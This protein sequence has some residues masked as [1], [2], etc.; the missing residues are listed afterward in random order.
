MRHRGELPPA[1]ALKER[2]FLQ[3]NMFMPPIIFRS[4]FSLFFSTGFRP[5]LDYIS[6]SAVTVTPRSLRLYMP[7]FEIFFLSVA[8]VTTSFP[9]FC[10]ATAPVIDYAASIAFFS[11]SSGKRRTILLLRQYCNNNTA[12]NTTAHARPIESYVLFFMPS[13]TLIFT[14]WGSCYAE[15]RCAAHAQRQRWRSDERSTGAQC[16]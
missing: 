7:R 6:S 2:Y 9:F 3:L 1:F 13:V 12:L 10:P 8:S 4:L 15:R 5:R 14:P 16:E 11:P